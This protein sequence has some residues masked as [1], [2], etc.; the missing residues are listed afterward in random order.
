MKL[1]PVRGT[2]DILG[3]EARLFFEIEQFFRISAKL[4]D[5]QEMETPIFEFT[6]VFKRTLGD[7]SDIV[8]KE[9]YTFEDRSGDS[10]T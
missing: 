8:N 10:L 4:F 6:Q 2:R 7:A 1:Q 9:M 5:F 3:D